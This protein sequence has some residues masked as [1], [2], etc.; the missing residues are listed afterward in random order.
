MDNN[1]SSYALRIFFVAE[2]AFDRV[3]TKRQKGERT[4]G[5]GDWKAFFNSM[6]NTFFD[7]LKGKW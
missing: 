4:K 6:T 7:F 1:R 5:K 2:G 3:F